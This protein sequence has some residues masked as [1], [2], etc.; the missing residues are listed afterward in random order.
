MVVEPKSQYNNNVNDDDVVCIGEIQHDYMDITPFAP[1]S[2]AKIWFE[3][4]VIEN[5]KPI[6]YLDYDYYKIEKINDV[7][8]FNNKLHYKCQLK[9]FPNTNKIIDESDCECSELINQFYEDQFNYKNEQ[10]IYEVN[11]E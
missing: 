11:Y 4:T 10:P 2:R 1:L 8:L 6:T 3:K 9:N 5:N 7:R